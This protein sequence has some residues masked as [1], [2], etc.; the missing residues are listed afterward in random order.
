MPARPAEIASDRRPGERL[1]SVVLHDVAPST[2]PLYRDFVK[3][4]DGI[5][6]IPLSLLV[7]PD[8]HHEGSI[9]D[10]RAFR[11][12]MDARIARGDELVLHGFHHADEAPPPRRPRDVFMRRIYTHEGEFQAIAAADARV[13]IANGLA[14]FAACGWSARGFV[15]PAW[16]LNDASKRE[17]AAAA[18]DYTSDPQH[19]IRLPDWQRIHA[20][21]LVWSARSSWRRVLSR[22]WNDRQ[23]H[24]H[25]D[26]PL[27]RLGLH[28]VDMRHASVVRWWLDAVVTLGT[29]RM[30]AT[31][32][33][34]LDRLVEQSTAWEHAA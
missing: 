27:L 12:E 7:V 16:L 26:A 17:V 6:A 8:F 24:R 19:L 23:R 11:A 3:A 29:T 5:G 2:W 25:A 10:D 32:S 9:A 31:K 18:F 20:P 13:R 28:P 1:F 34:A 21:G 14:A 22:A 15:A 30:P 33:Q 4:I